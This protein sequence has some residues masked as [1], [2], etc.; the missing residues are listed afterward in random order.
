MHGDYDVDGVSSTAILVRALRT[1]GADVDWYLPCRIDDGYG[2]ALATVEKLA[3][4][5]TNLLITVDCAVTAVEEVARGQGARARRRGHRPSPPRADGV[6]PDAPIVHPRVNG[7]PCAD[8]CAAGVAYKLAQ[9]LLA[10]AGG[11]RRWR[12][13]TWTWSRWPRSPTSCR[14]RART[15]GSCAQGLRALAA[16]RKVGLR[17]LM[18][19]AR[20]DPS[21]LDE[22]AIGF[23]LGP[24]LN[25]AGRL[26]RAD[27]GLELLLTEDATAPA[28]S[29]P[30]STRSTP[31]AATSRPGSGSRPRRCGRPPG[32]ATRSCS[33]ARA[34]TRA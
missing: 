20:V 25:A 11:T 12:R 16:T 14:C 3:A 28:P 22:S 13:R 4:R 34:G 32:R 9:A 19:V 5:G 24:R 1:L 7:Y 33:P 29:P 31:S 23:R 10:A 27:A 17:A 15:A 30:S 2:L 26:Y 18:E 6:L 21:G 8:L